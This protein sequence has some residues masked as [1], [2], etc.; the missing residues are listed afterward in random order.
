MQKN[1]Q[2]KERLLDKIKLNELWDRNKA[3]WKVWDK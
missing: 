1:H 3:P 2:N